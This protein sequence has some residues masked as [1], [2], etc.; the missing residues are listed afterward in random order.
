MA[1]PNQSTKI[2]IGFFHALSKTRTE[3]NQYVFESMYKSAHSVLLGDIWAEEVPFAST[4][5]DAIQASVDFPEVV[6][7][8]VEFPLTPIPGSNGQ[9]WYINDERFVKPWIAPTDVAH[10][11]TGAASNGY[12]VN[13]YRENGALITPTEGVWMVDYYSGIVIFEPGYTPFDQGY[14]IPRI[15]CYVY[16]GK[17][18]DNSGL[19][20]NTGF[21]GDY[22]ITYTLGKANGQYLS[23]NGGKYSNILNN[24]NFPE[25]STIKTIYI[26]SYSGTDREISIRKNGVEIYSAMLSDG[27]Y[28][29]EDLTLNF[30]RNDLLTVFIPNIPGSP[31]QNVQASFGISNLKEEGFTGTFVSDGSTITVKNGIITSIL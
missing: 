9:A 30:D 11:S 10:P 12:Q 31:L 20:G 19:S 16:V 24:F 13:L 17:T 4:A 5:P 15:S 18:L 7:R 26:K 8:Y 25:N 23:Y 27:S 2:G 22:Y 29:A 1:Q 21:A 14:G 28:I 3:A 6:K